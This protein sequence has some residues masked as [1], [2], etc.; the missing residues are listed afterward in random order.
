MDNQ[1]FSVAYEN[2]QKWLTDKSAG[3]Q[4]VFADAYFDDIDLR[5]LNLNHAIFVDCTFGSLD[6]V[7]LIAASLTNCSFTGVLNGVDFTECQLTNVTFQGATFVEVHGI[8]WVSTTTAFRFGVFATKRTMTAVQM[9]SGD[10]HLYD[11]NNQFLTAEEWRL[12]MRELVSNAAKSNHFDADV[13]ARCDLVLA[14]L[15]LFLP[16]T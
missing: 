12:E 10:V 1:T 5:G 13:D 8:E 14:S 9:P 16:L 3:S 7:T 11:A 4:M 2:H 6:D 15:R